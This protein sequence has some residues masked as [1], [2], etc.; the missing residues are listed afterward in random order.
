MWGLFHYK[1][2]FKISFFLAGTK[3][4]LKETSQA[5]DLITPEQV[6][7]LHEEL[8][9]HDFATCSAKDLSSIERVIS[10]S[11]LKILEHQQQKRAAA[12][13]QSLCV[14][15]WNSNR[16]TYSENTESNI[17]LQLRVSYSSGNNTILTITIAPAHANY[18]DDSS[19]IKP[20]LTFL[21][22]EQRSY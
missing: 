6:Q 15:M 20:D 13:S 16:G 4:D 17:Q 19:P 7:K 22:S 3:Q 11:V 2:V 5:P 8:A 14:I 18:R 21:N 9:A 12:N 1:N 10:V